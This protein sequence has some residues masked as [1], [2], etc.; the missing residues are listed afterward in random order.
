MFVWLKTEQPEPPSPI[1]AKP[2]APPLKPVAKPVAA[3]TPTPATHPGA[4][5]P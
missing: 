4:K 2:S 1:P 3:K 5:T